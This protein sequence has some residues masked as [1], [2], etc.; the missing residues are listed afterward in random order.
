MNYQ[1]NKKKK[2]HI[3]KTTIKLCFKACKEIP[4]ATK[5]A[6]FKSNQ[7]AYII[8]YCEFALKF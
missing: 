8:G 5:E 4:Y 6:W 2:K 3:T 7:Q 1:N